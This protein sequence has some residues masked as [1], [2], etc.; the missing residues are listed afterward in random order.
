MDA[1]AALTWQGGWEPFVVFSADENGNM[2]SCTV[3]NGFGY[4]QLM[5]RKPRV[6]IYARMSF[7]SN[8]TMS[9]GD[10]FYGYYGYVEDDPEAGSP[11]VPSLRKCV[12]SIS[13]SLRS[14]IRLTDLF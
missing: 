1:Y 5:V 8:D 12:K 7:D 10:L 11:I 14:W 6:K 3:A 2:D 9:V 4:F 13:T